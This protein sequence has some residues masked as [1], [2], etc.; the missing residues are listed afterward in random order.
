MCLVVLAYGVD[1]DHRLIVAANRDEFH[2]R[3]TRAAEW[4]AD[5]PDVLGGRDLQA[6]GTW[7]ALHRS[8]RFAT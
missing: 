7:L 5:Q 1:E 2:A 3:P 4:W 6:G 8:G